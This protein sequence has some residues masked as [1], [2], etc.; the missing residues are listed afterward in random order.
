MNFEVISQ[1]NIYYFINL[2]KIYNY[3]RG[4]IFAKQ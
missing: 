3:E 4:K 1:T 2:L